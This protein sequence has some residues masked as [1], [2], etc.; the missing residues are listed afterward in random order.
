MKNVI[1]FLAALLAAA[2]ASAS[3][4]F[5]VYKVE[6]IAPE[7]APRIDGKLDDAVWDDR[8]AIETLRN[9]QGP[10]SGEFA[11]QRSEFIQLTDGVTLFIG[12][13]FHDREMD[14][15]RFNPV[16]APFWNDCIELYFAPRGEGIRHIQLVV[17]CGGQRMWHKKFDD[18]YGWWDDNS[19]HLLADW[20]AAVHRAADRWT[21]EIAINL[22]SFGIEAAPGHS[23]GF[24]PC[25]F[26][27][28]AEPQ[29]FSAWGV[30]P[31]GI[32]FGQKHMPSWG[33]LIFAPA[34]ERGQGT[35]A[36][37]ADVDLIYP[38]LANR[39]LEAP[40]DGGLTVFSRDGTRTVS[41]RDLLNP[42]LRRALADA[43]RAAAEIAK[44]PEGHP[45]RETL[46]RPVAA[47]T[48][49]LAR[50]EDELAGDDLTIGRYDKLS[51]DLGK[52]ADE[53]AERYWQTRLA[54]L[55]VTAH[56]GE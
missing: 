37:R 23:V 47:A 12:A 1:V 16:N 45:H 42:V 40:A 32:Y 17:D 8:P 19:W 38:D 2:A 7:D 51:A 4:R 46:G 20:Q 9:F 10:L 11:S 52:L 24:N 35:A 25:R 30:A 29:E 48:A 14:K 50:I 22:A 5:L 33:H 3:E 27:L 44:L 41:F 21:I 34:G 18:G 49:A 26:R 54:T 28:G 6:R 53:V 31:P 55:A 56:R 15:I 13:T 39:V 36:T 43:T